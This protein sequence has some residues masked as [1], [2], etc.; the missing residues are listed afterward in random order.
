M[1][2]AI[3]AR[4]STEQTGVSEEHKSVGRQVETPKAYAARQDWLLSGEDSLVQHACG[5]GRADAVGRGGSRHVVTPRIEREEALIGR[6]N[7]EALAGGTDLKSLA[8]TFNAAAGLSPRPRR[9]GRSLP[10]TASS[11]RAMVFNPL[12]T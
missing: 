4:K 9:A 5:A 6:Q 7:F 2:A 10:W 8:K 11:I 3:Y 1:M 12:Y